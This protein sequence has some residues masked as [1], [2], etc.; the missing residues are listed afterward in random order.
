M[1]KNI[2]LFTLSLLICQ[3]VF[4]QDSQPSFR[5]GNGL[6]GASGI[7]QGN[8]NAVQAFQ[9]TQERADVHYKAERYKQAFKLYHQLAEYNDK[10]SQYRVAYMYANGRGVE[11]DMTEAFAWSYV[12]S[13]TRQKGFVNYHVKVR[14]SLTP[15][16]IDSGKELAQEY[17][18]DYGT[19]AVASKARRLVRKQKGSC[20]GSRV[21][22]SCDRVTSVGINCGAAVEGTPDKECLTLGSVGLPGI[23]GMQPSDIRTVENHLK[24]MMDEYNPGRVELGDLE[25]IED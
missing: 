19:F 25:L 17:R 8:I 10:F 20:V 21:G 6:Q 24:D 9:K 5:I 2:V 15:E 16:Q 23:A 3:L 12:A 18:E 7:A 4:S 13:E 1:H 14:D 22:S 11:K